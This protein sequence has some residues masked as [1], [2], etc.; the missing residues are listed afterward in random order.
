MGIPVASRLPLGTAAAFAA[1]YGGPSHY[2]SPSSGTLSC[3]R[4]YPV[5]SPTP[6]TV[7]PRTSFVATGSDYSRL[8]FSRGTSSDWLNEVGTERPES[9]EET[10]SPGRRTPL[11]HCR[12]KLATT[13]RALWCHSLYELEYRIGHQ[14]ANRTEHP[15]SVGLVCQ[16][17]AH[18]G[19]TL[20][21]GWV[22]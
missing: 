10:N 6:P 12:G 20:S 9:A 2:L 22:Y 21:P 7:Y 1:F 11:T 18:L 13:G 17:C 15:G 8:R 19:S 3:L 14:N 5:G 16:V 4:L